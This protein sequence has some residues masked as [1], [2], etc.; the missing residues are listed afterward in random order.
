MLSFRCF[1]GGCAWKFV[2]AEECYHSLAVAQTGT[3]ACLQDC[4][5]SR[6]HKL[7]GKFSE[8]SENKVKE[9]A[10]NCRMGIPFIEPD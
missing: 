9:Q 1:A 2:K 5:L 10:Y 4:L 7:C 3:E 8:E 6:E